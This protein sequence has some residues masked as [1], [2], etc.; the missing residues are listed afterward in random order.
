MTQSKS[1][2]WNDRLAIIDHYNPKDSEVIAVMGVTQDELDTARD[3][4]NSGIMKPTPDLDLESYASMF[5][6]DNKSV[7]KPAKKTAATTTSTKTTKAKKTTTPQ[8]ANKPVK[9]PK[10]RGRK[11]DKISVAFNAIPTTATPVEKFAQDNNVS[12]AVL[13]QSKRFDPAPHL[14]NVKVKKNKTTKVLEIWREAP[15]AKS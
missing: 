15:D 6:G 10:K 8:T 14:G 4:R 2:S 12:V 1:L 9:V 7:T 3:M 11:G 13:R 5:G